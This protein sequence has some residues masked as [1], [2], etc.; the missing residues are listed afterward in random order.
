MFWSCQPAIQFTRRASGNGLAVAVNGSANVIQHSMDTDAAAKLE[1]ALFRL[2][3]EH[4]YPY[5][6]QSERQMMEAAAGTDTGRD[7]KMI[8]SLT[9]RYG[10]GDLPPERFVAFLREHTRTYTDVEQWHAAMRQFDFVLGSRFHGCLIAILAGVPA[11]VFVHD[12]RTREM[13]EVLNI[14]HVEVTK[15]N[16]VDV[17]ALYESLDL[18]AMQTAYRYLFQNYIDFLEE[19]QIEHRLSRFT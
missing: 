9:A 2:A 16:G 1:S 18:D 13:C 14:P 11:F 15:A 17:R 6:F 3:F 12:T 8:R 4:G 10:L 19:N 7:E 5:V